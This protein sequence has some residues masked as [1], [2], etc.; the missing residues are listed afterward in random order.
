MEEK[1]K[2]INELD[3]FTRQLLE[4]KGFAFMWVYKPL[5]PDC[6]KSRLKKLKKRDKFY[7]CESCNK[8]FEKPEYNSLLKYNIEYTCPKCSK[9]GEASGDWIK[10]TSKKSAVMQKFTCS[11]CGEK[12]KVARISKKKK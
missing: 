9:K 3:F 8:T 2:D 11:S 12:L 5:C 6:N 7:A 4:P 1:P 10:P